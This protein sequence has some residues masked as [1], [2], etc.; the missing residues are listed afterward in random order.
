MIL[1]IL[2]QKV[3]QHIVM[4]YQLG[5][6]IGIEPLK[7]EIT[8]RK[9]LVISSATILLSKWEDGFLKSLAGQISE[10]R[11]KNHLNQARIAR[12]CAHWI[13]SSAQVKA[14]TNVGAGQNLFHISSPSGNGMAIQGSSNFT[15]SGL[16]ETASNILEMNKVASPTLFLINQT[17]KPPT[18]PLSRPSPKLHIGTIF[19]P[20]AKPHHWKASL[21]KKMCA[22]T[23][24]A[25]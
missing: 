9:R 16:G 19:S 15:A 20:V 8:L 10:L 13:K 17:L 3:L 5:S 1:Q 11:V 25:K 14:L 4:L 23:I 7:R 2:I 21:S 24:S 22:P 18:K 6:L 12:E